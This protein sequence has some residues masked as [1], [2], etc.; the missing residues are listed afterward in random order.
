MF[1]KI[2][3]GSFRIKSTD[4]E[5]SPADKNTGHDY[6]IG[7][8]DQDDSNKDTT[9]ALAQLIQKFDQIVQ[10]TQESSELTD[11]N[12]QAS[13]AMGKSKGSGVPVNIL[14]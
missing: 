5:A 11:A 2:T 7:K 12:A 4:T 3:S 10:L 13:N 1:K 9:E 8:D 6:G 14:A